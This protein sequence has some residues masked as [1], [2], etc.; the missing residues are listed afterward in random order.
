MRRGGHRDWWV[1]GRV[2]DVHCEELAVY[3][4]NTVW[5][6]A[7][8]RQ[9]EISSTLLGLFCFA[10]LIESRI[11]SNH[12]SNV[13]IHSEQRP[14]ALTLF[15]VWAR[16]HCFLVRCDSIHDDCNWNSTMRGGR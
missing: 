11:S 4:D 2:L 6:N 15:V 13:S 8:K 3:I 10:I 1:V 14:R 5:P 9:N 16:L 12:G 7:R